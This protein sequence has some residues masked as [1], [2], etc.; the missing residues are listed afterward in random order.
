MS[1]LKQRLDGIDNLPAPDLWRRAQHEATDSH[2]MGQSTFRRGAV[3]AAALLISA[4]AIGFLLLAFRPQHASQPATPTPVANGDIWVQVGGGD[5]PTAIYRVDPDM[6]QIP[7]A[8]WSDSRS[9]GGAEVAPELLAD[10][11]AFSPDGSEVV[12]SQQT[13]E[14]GADTTRELFIMNADG[15]GVRQLTHDGAY[16]GFPAWSPDGR[17]IAYASYRGSDYIPGCLGFSIC[18]TDLYLIDATGGTPRPFATN[19]DVSETTPSWSP[20][21][22]RLAFAEI[23]RDGV[24]SIVNV[25]VDGSDRVELSPSGKVSFPSWSPDGRS[26]LFLLAQDGTNLLV[27]APP[28]DSGHHVVTDTHTDTNFGRPVWSP[29]GQLIAYARPYAGTTSLWTIDAAGDRPPERVAG[30]P[31]YDA[32]P[33]AWQ[34][35]PGSANAPSEATDP[36]LTGDPRVVASIDLPPDTMAGSIS[37][38]AGAVWVDAFPTT[39]GAEDQL[40][41]IDPAT[42]HVETVASISGGK[43]A[44]TDDAVWAAGGQELE[45]FDPRTGGLVATVALPGDASAIAANETDVWVIVVTD[46]GSMLIRVD[47]ATN[48]VSAQIPLGSEFTG[49]QDSVQLGEGAVWLL[50]VRWNGS[51]QDSKEF[52]GDLVRVD[53]VSNQV[54]DRIPVDGFSMAVGQ[55]AVW[56][57]FPEDGVFDTYQE[58]W[59]W[60]KVDVS[61]DQPSQPFRM[62]TSNIGLV[63][64]DVL[65]AVDYDNQTDVR[66]SR[67]DPTT[68]QV[69]V[70][71]DPIRGYYEGEAFDPSTGTVWIGTMTTVTRVDISS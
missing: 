25:A 63:T 64:P 1:D 3:I 37:V 61:N 29:D 9:F 6:K 66:V 58:R 38:G 32:S 43:V 4:A 18:P 17:T 14:G 53:P 69:L 7:K 67:F 35:I 15:S 27:T 31:G 16:A 57:K 2:V 48:A 28:T 42:D 12:F 47:P 34:P 46:N 5:G 56:V 26:I 8:M 36:P 40:L 30:W 33:V 65:W 45:R 21:G 24:G 13:H 22:S 68:H 62:D 44:A 70:R 20:D 50:G 55:D 11:Y 54:V 10:D 71:S 41:R 19:A 51:D 39:K 52:G 23:G 59:L 60:T 49:Y